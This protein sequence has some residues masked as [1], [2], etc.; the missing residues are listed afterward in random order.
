MAGHKIGCTTPVMQAYL[1]IHNPCAGGVFDTTVFHERANIQQARFLRLGVE[2]EIAVRLRSPL[3]PEKSPFD[4]AKV[5]AAVGSCMAAIEIVEDR[6][7]DYPSLDTPTLIAD[8]F[9]NAGCV[10]G[11]ELTNFDPHDLTGVTATMTINGH[12]VGSGV[13]ADVLG[14]PLDALVWLANDMTAR[15]MSLAEE[16][17]VVLGSLVQTNW[18]EAGDE[19]VIANDPL[20]EV[21]ATFV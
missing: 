9:F 15:G 13:G 10:L 14:H 1:G 4:R 7:V 3:S 19:V 8:D 21:R 17:F 20:G 16:E 2:C 5:A 18:V 11:E 6:Y 12:Q